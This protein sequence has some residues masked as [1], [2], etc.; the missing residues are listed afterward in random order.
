MNFVNS[1]PDVAT[2]S[3]QIR[4]TRLW[5]TFSIIILLLCITNSIPQDHVMPDS[6]RLE[7]VENVS[8]AK[9][10]LTAKRGPTTVTHV[11]LEWCLMLDQ[12]RQMIVVLVSSQYYNELC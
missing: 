4:M 12:H 11:H 6:L 8:Y 1:C 5:H 2:T 3:C 10:I 7:E 9:R